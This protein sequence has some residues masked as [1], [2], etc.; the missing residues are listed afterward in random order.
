MTALASG[1]GLACQNASL[2][3]S[4]SPSTSSY[5]T[6][7]GKLTPQQT[8][9]TTQTSPSPSKRAASPQLSSKRTYISTSTFPAPPLTCQASSKVS[10][11]VDYYESSNSQAINKCENSTCNNS[12]NASLHVDTHIRTSSQFSKNILQNIP[13]LPVLHLPQPLVYHP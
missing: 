12:T 10:S 13:Q 2:S 8:A 9:S 1:T 7:N 3:S 4:L 5:I 6:S 11:L